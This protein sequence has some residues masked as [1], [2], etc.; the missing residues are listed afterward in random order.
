LWQ[1]NNNETV[2]KTLSEVMAS[3]NLDNITKDIYAMLVTQQELLEQTIAANLNVAENELAAA[4]G[5]SFDNRETVTWNARNQLSGAEQTVHLPQ[6]LIGQQPVTLNTDIKS[7]SP[8]VD[9]V[10]ALVGGASTI[11]Q[12]MNNDGDMLRVV[13]NVV[14]GDGKRAI[15][16][17]IPAA[18]P[19]GQPNPIL[20][21]VLAGERYVGRAFVVN[22]WYIAAYEPIMGTDGKV[23]GMLFVGV[24]EQSTVNLRE[25]IMKT[26]VGETGY[27]YVLDSKGTYIV[28]YNGE[29][30]G[31][32]IWEAKDADGRLIIQD[33]VKTA[34]VLKPVEVAHF[35]YLWK[36]PGEAEARMK[37]AGVMYFAPWDWVIGTGG[38][39]D[40]FNQSSL[41][42]HAANRRGIFLLAGV[43][44]L[45]LAGAALLWMLV[46]G[47]I[48]RPISRIT[49]IIKDISEGEG[50]L[51]RRL[52]GTSQDEVGKLAG[53][54]N[55]FVSKIQA[56]I[57][58]IHASTNSVASS[59]TELTAISEETSAGA[60]ESLN[61][62][63]SVA[64]AAEEMSANTISVAAG[65]EQASTS[66]NSVASAVEE[67][68]TTIGEIARNSEKAHV[69]ADQAARQ[70]SQ[71]SVIM[72]GLGQSAQ[73]IGK[74]TET[75]TSIS[76]QTNL[77][78][79]NAT[80]E[81]ARAGVTGKGFAV[82]ASE[83]KELAQQTAAATSEIKD[84]IGTIQG[85]TA[86]AVAD[87]DN[88]V[89]VIS[90]VNEIVITIATAIQEQ[91]TVTH[92]IAGNIA[93]ASSGVRDANVRVA[94][95]ATVSSSI[96]KEI[97]E[98]SIAT[99]QMASAS[100][101]V[102]TSAMELSQL[103]ESLS[104]MVSQFK[105]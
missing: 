79:L 43:F 41:T 45:C 66:L 64:A 73:E 65:M 37:I 70:V 53:Y 84:K 28:S 17:F 102:Q 48:T 34:L 97:A 63:N 35:R 7:P 62:T 85:S 88:I 47:G 6:M 96:A 52:S 13:T 40:D 1:F 16:T 46:A 24:P 58:G 99:G 11:F 42:I 22:A 12:R 44:G 104:L 80:I 33:I 87:I 49:G 27:V 26:K 2:A 19:D 4:G 10:K 29:R 100:S 8:V 60:R 55:D 61:K 39:E 78:A 67:M 59:A 38:Y 25:A 54:F 9:K 72:K 92:D 21:K 103:A 90:E 81:A 30:D 82:V 23:A 105:V 31:E 95:T 77:L 89:Q 32:V 15:N 3:E 83:V 86:G 14:S 98:V 68:T 36:N 71:F 57:Q 75:I 56:L 69:T 20:L 18:N 74:V 50:D 93:Q 51:T 91:S 94:Q 5:T 76:T 101:Q